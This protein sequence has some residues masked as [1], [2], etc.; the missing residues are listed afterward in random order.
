LNIGIIIAFG[1]VG[2]STVK[3][4]HAQVANATFALPALPAAA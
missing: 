2:G 3:Q 1:Y 4:E